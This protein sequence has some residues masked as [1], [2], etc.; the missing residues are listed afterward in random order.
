MLF[1]VGAHSHIRGLGVDDTL[2]PR[3]TSQGMVGQPRARKA[4]AVVLKMIEAGKVC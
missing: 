4:A 1:I 2:E 3:A